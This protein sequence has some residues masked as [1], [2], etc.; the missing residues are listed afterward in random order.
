MSEETH[1][2]SSQRTTQALSN[3]PLGVPTKELRNEGDFSLS[4]KGSILS[5]NT[6]F[7]MIIIL[8]RA[9]GKY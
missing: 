1:A 9:I 5:Y 3:S 2:K 8:C 6:L 7:A 4:H